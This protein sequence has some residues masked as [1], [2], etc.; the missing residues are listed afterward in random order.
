MKKKLLIFH[1]VI[2]P[3]RIDF[4]NALAE[5]FCTTICLFWRNLKDQNFDYP[6]IQAQFRFKEQ[7]L[8]REEMGLLSW[9][10]GIWK[11]I[12]IV[13]PNMVIGAEFGMSTIILIIHK[14]LTYSRYKIF[15]MSDDSYDMI[16]HH[17]Q[18]SFRHTLAKKLLL[19]FI[20]NLIVPDASV[21]EYYQ[22][23][24]R[25]GIWF[26]IIYDDIHMREK[27]QSLLPL[28]NEYISKYRLA[29]KKVLLF[30]GRL[31]QIKNLSFALKCFLRVNDHESVFVIVG[32]G[33][34]FPHLAQI[35][36]ESPNV[37]FTGRLEGDALYA[38]YNVAQCLILPSTQE[39]F[40]AVVG[41]ALAAG[42]MCLVSQR[43]GS[44]CLIQD[45][46]N[47]Y[48]FNPLCEQE[49][50]ATMEKAFLTVDPIRRPLRVRE[51]SLLTSFRD[52]ME[53]LVNVI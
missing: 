31:V 16:A 37:I 13:K 6:K 41:E 33:P 44:S 38:W 26:P 30:V 40:G 42:C 27:Y 18:F 28:S 12:N 46:L 11:M 5:R 29:G 9:I 32:D 34:E 17:N 35:A 8:I 10:K 43:A 36:A 25:K 19:P 23:K 39:P 24:C 48:I 45:V 47:G 53:S 14:Y 51:C 1:P 7:Y 50:M 2:A 21:A 49:L 22:K 3:Y 52:C 20:D 15:I 4:F